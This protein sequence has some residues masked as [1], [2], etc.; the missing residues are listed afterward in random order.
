MTIYDKAVL[1]V[2]AANLGFIR[3]TLEKVLRLI[4]ILDFV[5][6]DPLLANSLALKGGT[7]I[8]LTVFDMPRLSVDID[9]DYT[10]NNSLEEM[11]S[12]REQITRILGRYMAGAGYHAS[13]KS[14]EHYSL[15]GR[16]WSYTNA[17]GASDNVKIEIN[18]SMRAHILPTE[19]RAVL[20]LNQGSV[21]TLAPVEIYASKL[22][23]LLTR[24][25][26]R[27]LYDINHMIDAN[28]FTE[29]AE[30]DLLRRCV[31]F[32]LAIG[33][34][35]VPDLAD[36]SRIEALTPHRIRIDLQP[37]L[38]KRDWFDLSA[39]QQRVVTYLKELLRLEPDERE[40]LA[41]FQKG[42][43]KPELIFEGDQLDRVQRHPMAEW[44]LRVR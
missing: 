41:A 19:R 8:N 37:V 32:Y 42:L 4:E 39:A 11:T 24:T 27:D 43:W 2:Q 29:P 13:S 33:T 9:L 25:A 30:Q 12:Q 14:R 31:V 35:K 5:N 10:R 44:K 28:L 22:V 40:F 6:V 34:E 26:A 36:F 16:V 38:R 17:A 23:A 15:D 1:G 7:A 21:V 3:D 18:Y 20:L